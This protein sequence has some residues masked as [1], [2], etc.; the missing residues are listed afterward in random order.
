M[1][2]IQPLSQ[3][4]IPDESLIVGMFKGNRK[5]QTFYSKLNEQMDNMLEH[6][7]Q[8][9]DIRD[10]AQKVTVIHTLN[11]INPKRL[12]IVGLGHRK[13]LDLQ[14]LRKVF[15][16]VFKKIQEDER[17]SVSIVLESFVP[18][19]LS[20]KVAA[21][22]LAEAKQMATYIFPH[23]KT[24]NEQSKKR[25]DRI[26]VLVSE[27]ERDIQNAIT[28]GQAFGIG[29]NTARQLVHM[30]G[31]LLNATELANFS[32]K[33]A[34]KYGFDIE[35]LEKEDMERLGM[36]ALLAVN[37]GSVEPPKMIVLKY[38]GKEK[39]E[40]VIGLVGKG[41]TFDTGGYSL[42]T[43]DGI[44]GMKTDMG[45]AASV[46]GAMETM[47][48]LKPRN[49]VVAVIPATDNMISGSAF[50]PD[51]VVTSFSGKTIEV[52]NTDAEGR[53]ALADAIVY[54]RHH[55]A[56]RIIDVATL[57]GGVVVA[58]GDWVTGAM[59]NNI[60]LYEKIE[61]AS[62]YTGEP[63]WQLPYFDVYRDQVRKSEIADLNNSPGRKA[64][65]IMGGAFLGEF[66]EQ[67][68]W[69]HLDIAGTAVSDQPHELGPKGPTGVMARTLA[70]FVI[71]EK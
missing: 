24:G 26:R 55:R 23:Y 29:A 56:E 62:R 31:N 46:L 44:V 20:E 22:V 12:Y 41:I 49:N 59:T 70:K 48:I 67:T 39:W 69:V 7:V 11:Q 30:P 47:G 35:I 68:P 3:W 71:E 18:D 38:Q 51:D 50:K 66:A 2:T 5:Q 32:R 52:R 10:D 58:L 37:Q 15:G 65:P 54:A 25:I 60:E 16:T 34:E 4:D 17:E 42:K 19:H 63:I 9:G 13:Q 40:D 45:G 64:H 1:F 43:K 8:E 28:V 14:T 57:T 27:D 61:E 6:Y 36:G 53:L 21:E 33:L